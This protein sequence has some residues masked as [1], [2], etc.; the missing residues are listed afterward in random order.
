MKTETKPQ[1]INLADLSFKQLEKL[2]DLEF[3]NMV[4]GKHTAAYIALKEGLKKKN[5]TKK[6]D[7]LND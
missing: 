4:N 5:N 3:D 1:S 7:K 2:V 6:N